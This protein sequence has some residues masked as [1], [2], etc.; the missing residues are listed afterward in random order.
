MDNRPTVDMHSIATL[1]RKYMDKIIKRYI[2]YGHKNLLSY[3]DP[4]G[5]YRASNPWKT[6]DTGPVFSH[7]LLETSAQQTSEPGRQGCLTGFALLMRHVRLWE[8][9]ITGEAKYAQPFAPNL[10][11]S[12]F[13]LS[14]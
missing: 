9:G 10:I 3:K 8:M 11:F 13:V 4:P 12:K 5:G 6:D 1:S 14:E 7:A 2:K